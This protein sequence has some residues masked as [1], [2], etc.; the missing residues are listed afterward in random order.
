MSDKKNVD[1]NVIYCGL[2]PDAGRFR[3]SQ[4]GL[5]W[6]GTRDRTI[7]VGT[8]EL[9][10]MSWTRAARGFELR[11]LKKDNTVLKFDGFKPDVC[12]FRYIRSALGTLNLFLIVGF[13]GIKGSHQGIL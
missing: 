1:F 7:I 12:I 8:D 5:G 11:V 2:Q 13:G 9:K 4:N 6:K 3:L 10:K